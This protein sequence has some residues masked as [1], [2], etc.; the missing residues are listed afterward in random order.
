MK[1]SA[2]LSLLVGFGLPALSQTAPVAATPAG[3][4]G[5]VLSE[6]R[7]K[8]QRIQQAR[9]AH[10]E[11]GKSSRDF[12]A[13]VA[14]DLADLFTRLAKERRPELRQAL[15]VSQLFLL[16]Q[17]RETP[18]PELLALVFREVPA[19]YGGWALDKGLLLSLAAWAPTASEPYL[20]TARAAFPDGAIR[21]NL[22]FE[23]F[24]EM[25][26]T[27]TEAAWRPPYQALLKDFPGTPE[28][29]KAAERLASEAKTAVGVAAPPFS[30]P[31]LEA[32]GTVYTVAT[33]KGHYV[34]LDFWA[35]WCP[36]CVAEMPAVH[37]AYARF[38]D[39][40]LEILSL[41][42]DRKVE[43][44]APYRKHAATPMPWKHTFL[45]GAFKNPL[46]EAYGVKSIPK[47]VLVGPDGRI[48]ANGGQLH[49]ANLEK[50][51]E[52]FLG[53]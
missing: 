8:G 13:D 35:T 21:R 48:V 2:L 18:S 20:A 39:K 9:A 45:E 32:P 1:T 11:A 24:T 3:E 53:K 29:V 41:S 31:A 16:R 49:G 30:V 43:H 26:D 33:F 22:L 6:A 25:I 15:I 42:F 19:T 28:A 50:T 12:K 23:Y 4:A 7:L 37:K 47:P 14:A 5:A 44:I 51:L 17:A 40:G 34:L 38:K 27:S 36:D 46:S 10:I 52:Q